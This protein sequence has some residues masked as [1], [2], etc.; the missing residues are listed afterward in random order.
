MSKYSADQLVET[1]INLRNMLSERSEKFEKGGASPEEQQLVAALKAIATVDGIGT[2]IQ[3]MCDEAARLIERL[4]TP[5][6]TFKKSM[7]AIE[8]LADQMI[9]ETGQTALKTEHGIAFHAQSLSVRC[10][11][12]DAF[13]DYV[14]EHNAR[15]MLTAG[16]SKEAIKEFMDAN[17]GLAPPGIITESFTKVQFRAS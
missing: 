16:A 13:F 3:V 12:R 7:L 6:A 10:A 2:Q 14:F 11:D 15:H 9:K 5:Q 17:G 1:Y 4:L 8:A